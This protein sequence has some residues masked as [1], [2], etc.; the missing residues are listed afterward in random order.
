MTLLKSISNSQKVL[1]IA[2][3][4][5][6]IINTS[7]TVYHVDNKT[8]VLKNSFFYE[9]NLLQTPN[10]YSYLNDNEFIYLINQRVI[11]VRTLFLKN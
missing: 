8:N 6:L 3:V 5:A 9:C 10:V 11:K 1:S 7:S 2:E 4:D